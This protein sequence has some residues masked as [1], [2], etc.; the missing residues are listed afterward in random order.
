MRRNIRTTLVGCSMLG[1]MVTTLMARDLENGQKLA[2]QCSVCHGKQGIASDPE[3]PN[4]AG[5][6]AF[7]L[8]KSMKSF[9]SGERQERR[10]SLVIK[11]LTDEEILDLAEWFSTFV[12]TVERP[13]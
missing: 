1:L 11:D 13:E 5:Q 10:M 4:L 12:V 9:R 3:V 8:E 7:Y 2:R 6:S